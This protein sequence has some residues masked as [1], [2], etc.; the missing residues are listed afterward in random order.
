MC[1]HDWTILKMKI[2]I[3][4]ARSINPFIIL[5]L[6]QYYT[7]TCVGL[8]ILLYVLQMYIYESIYLCLSTVS[9][10]MH[11]CYRHKCKAQEQEVTFS[12]KQFA[13]E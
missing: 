6:K 12:I 2:N 7:K 9:V 1:N 11:K 10:N 13:L 8:K 4:R 5:K 3:D